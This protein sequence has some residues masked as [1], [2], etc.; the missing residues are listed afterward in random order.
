MVDVPPEVPPGRLPRDL[1][2]DRDRCKLSGY[3][4]G[5]AVRMAQVRGCPP[6]GEMRLEQAA[7]KGV[8]R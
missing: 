7:E 5:G 6:R 2:A 1:I 4:V 8:V 3:V